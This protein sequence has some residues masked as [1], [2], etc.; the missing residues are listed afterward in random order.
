M[1]A[2]GTHSSVWSA[3]WCSRRKECRRGCVGPER[4]PPASS[5]RSLSSL[6]TRVS[7]DADQGGQL[8]PRA[9]CPRPRWNSSQR[10][11]LA[12]PSLALTGPTWNSWFPGRSCS[13]VR[14]C[15]LA[16]V[17]GLDS[18]GRRCSLFPLKGGV[19]DL[20]RTPSCPPGKQP[21]GSRRDS[22]E[23]VPIGFA[24]GLARGARGTGGTGGRT[25]SAAA[26]RLARASVGRPR[27]SGW[28][29]V[30]RPADAVPA[31]VPN[32]IPPVCSNL[33]DHLRH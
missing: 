17:K 9:I 8:A 33:L 14:L 13:L 4:A 29:P 6:M 32:D 10:P 7:A 1:L 22:R 5:A 23:S 25:A 16:Y 2:A 31:A 19:A 27:A 12:K 3:A 18:R 11:S 21:P 28:A 26:S 30:V 24:F 20:A 15:F